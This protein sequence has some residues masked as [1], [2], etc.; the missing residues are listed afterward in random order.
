MDLNLLLL[1]LHLVHFLLEG[2]VQQVAGLRVAEHLFVRVFEDLL[3]VVLSSV[4]AVTRSYSVVHVPASNYL[5]K[6][7]RVI[8]SGYFF[9]GNG[10]LDLQIGSCFFRASA[11]N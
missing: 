7:C 5:L 8:Y 3:D 1:S 11:L 2:V 10:A 4:L 9:L 6:H